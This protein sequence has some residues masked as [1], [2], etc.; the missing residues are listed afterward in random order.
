MAF[1]LYSRRRV[2]LQNDGMNPD[3]IISDSPAT[4]SDHFISG[5]GLAQLYYGA[6]RLGLPAAEILQRCGLDPATSLQPMARVATW[7]AEAF[8]Q[9]LLLSS[10]DELLGLHIGQQMMPAIFNTMTTLAFSAASLREAL[11]FTTKYQALIGGNSGG[12]HLENRDNGNMV[13]TASMVTQQPVL[14]RHLMTNLMLL[15][16]SMVRFI[17]GQPNLTACRVQLEHAPVNDEEKA[18]LESIFLCPV[19]FGAASN[20]VELDANTLNLPINVF[21]DQ[22][23]VQAEAAARQQLEEVEKQQ[24]LASQLR[25]LARDLMLSGLP[26]RKTVADRLGIS[27]RTLDRRM[28]EQGLSW[29]ELL[30]ETRQQLAQDYLKITD[31][32]VADISQRLGFSDT[33]SFQRRFQQ[34]TGLSPS[35]YREAL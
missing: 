34:W 26:R 29:Q 9:E 30:D 20:L 11:T 12:F 24:D 16:T 8:L 1:D 27:L 28:A 7:Q 17:T 15:A 21:N 25:W 22:R 32:T 6:E 33:R 2:L 18:I 3:S 23:L 31:M 13:L 4:D 10:Q 14:R 5:I 35:R 19:T